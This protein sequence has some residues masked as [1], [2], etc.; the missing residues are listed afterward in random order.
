MVFVGTPHF[1][2]IGVN[3]KNGGSVTRGCER[4]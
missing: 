4:A 1:F 3:P 2:D